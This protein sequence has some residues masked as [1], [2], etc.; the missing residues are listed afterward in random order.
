VPGEDVDDV[1]EPA[2]QRPEL[3]VAEPDPPVDDG[4][5]G[6][7]QLVGQPL[8]PLGRHVGDLGDPGGRPVGGQAA[9]RVD[10]V[11]GDQVGHRR[12]AQVDQPV[13]EQHVDH[14]EQQRGVGPRRDRQPLAG[15]L[16]G[17]G[18]AGIDHH[19]LAAPLLDGGD[20]AHHVR[21][22]EQRALRGVRVGAHDHQQVGPPDVG[23]RDRP[24]AA[25]HEVRADVLGPLVDD[26]GRVDHRDP[27]HADEDPDVAAQ[28][29]GV[30]Q[31]VADVGGDGADAVLLDHRQEQLGAAVERL[32]PAHLGERAVVPAHHRLAQPVGI[33]VQVAERRPLGAEVPLGPHVVT[34]GADQLDP[35]A[36]HVDL[37]PAHRL[38]QR[39]G[40]QVHL[41][42]RL[43]RRCPGFPHGR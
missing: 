32:V 29:H 28:V 38:A 43:T 26:A 4:P 6:G 5:L 22:G 39:A 27:G 33:V 24:H 40:A 10:T 3:L 16:G 15:P 2:G 14:G 19:D 34:V 25:V 20:L 18:A 7:G 13:G 42:L 30:G 11:R 17:P 41:P 1:D 35:L 23:H 9:Q 31:R 12:R 8:D 36:A 21:A 37:Q